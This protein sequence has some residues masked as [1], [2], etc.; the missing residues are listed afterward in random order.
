MNESD[1][2]KY[3]T[4]KASSSSSSSKDK[5]FFTIR[6]PTNTIQRPS[7]KDITNINNHKSSSLKQSSP[8]VSISPNVIGLS[9]FSTQNKSDKNDRSLFNEIN[10]LNNSDDISNDHANNDA[11]K[12][13][14]KNVDLMD[15]LH[16]IGDH[17]KYNM[18]NDIKENAESNKLIHIGINNDN[19]NYHVNQLMKEEGVIRDD[20]DHY[21]DNHHHQIN[22]NNSNNED[23]M[24]TQMETNHHQDS[25]M[26]YIFK[27]LFG[28][29]G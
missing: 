4:M 26:S 16:L 15:S 9:S 1:F 3:I 21:D 29:N 2:N 10:I 20:Q 17:S 12:T 25:W 6:G 18:K 28:W 14:K 13:K 22:D 11:N 27:Y 19:D 8:L 24:D 23:V 7:F 5:V